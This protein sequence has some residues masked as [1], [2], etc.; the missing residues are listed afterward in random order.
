M[1]GSVTWCYIPGHLVFVLVSTEWVMMCLA[2]D[3]P[4]SFKIWAVV[5]FLEAKN[6][7]AAEIY[8]E[9]YMVY[10]QNVM[11]EG[12]VRQ[13]CRMFDDGRTNGQ[14]EE[15]T[16][17]PC[18]MSNLVQSVDQQ[19][20]ERWHFIISERSCEFPQILC[21]VLREIIAYR[22]GCHNFCT[23]WVLKM[24][25]GAHKTWKMASA[26]ALL[27]PYY[28]NGYEL[29]CHIQITSDEKVKLSLCLTN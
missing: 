3:N 13:W 1:Q 27:Q 26:L 25:T 15:R 16:G 20:C 17:R 18:V 9:L 29:L 6:M 4:D 23:R 12:T 19:I 5:C 24:L 11:N 7:S 2:I 22:L 14:D 21:T 8:C 10:G 28:K